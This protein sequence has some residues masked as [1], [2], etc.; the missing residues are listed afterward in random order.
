MIK[1]IPCIWDETMVLPISEIGEIA[2]FARRRG[3]TW[4]L[5]ILNGTTAR[6]VDIPLAFLPGGE[7]NAMIVRDK[8]DDPAAVVVEKTK[9]AKRDLLKIEM[10]A[11]GGFIARF[12]P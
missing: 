5:T 6:S 10:R 1:S 11:G 12:S 3:N 7:Q 4:F 9:A 8:L 2:A